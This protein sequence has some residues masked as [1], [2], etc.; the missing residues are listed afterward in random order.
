MNS[1]KH[2]GVI[3]MI[4]GFLTAL[5][6]CAEDP[7]KHGDWTT[8]TMHRTSSVMTDSY[9]FAITKTDSGMTVTGFCYV[10]DAE[11]RVEGT[12]LSAGTEFLLR[13]ADLASRPTHKSKKSTAVD[14][15]QD[16]ETVMHADG[17]ERIISLSSEERAELNAALAA[18]IRSA[19]EGLSHGTWT[20]LYLDFS[21]DNYSEGY[22][23]EVLRSDG[24][25]IAKGTCSVY[26]EADGGYCAYASEDGF[27]LDV[28]TADA[29]NAL[30]L[31]RYPATRT[32]EPD[33]DLAEILDG[34]SGG[35]TLGFADGARLKKASPASVDDLIADLL[36]AEFAQKAALQ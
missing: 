8:F 19:A 12:Y 36:K 30:G 15:A 1:V 24:V 31:E 18:D 35:L 4:L 34:S 9:H 28:A 23:F 21:S 32:I 3:L 5:F 6:G 10:D 26:D 27:A 14:M 13:Q 33:G 29:I 2:F 20:Q 16:T 17:E 11:Y 25:W 7:A 22:S